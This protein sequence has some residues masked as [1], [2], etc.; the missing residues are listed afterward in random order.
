VGSA[1]EGTS[2]RNVYA[3]KDGGWV[4]IRP[5][6]QAMT[7]K[8]FSAFGRDDLNRDPAFKTNGE[9]GEAP[10]RRSTAIVGGFIKQRTLAD[11]ISFF[12]AAEVTAAPVYDIGQFLEDPHV[13]ERGIVVEAPD[14]DMGEVP[15][16]AWCRGSAA[17]PAACARRRRPSASTTA[18][19]SPA[20]ATPTSA[21]PRSLR[22]AS[23]DMAVHRARRSSLILPVNQ[24]RFVEKAYT[25]GADAIVLDLEDSVPPQEKATARKLVQGSL[26]VAGAAA[27]RCW[28]A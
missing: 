26:A 8:L 24:P 23:S 7:E 15:M 3:T 6:T 18:R 10:R 28:C 12:E 21:S 17:R 5:R 25:R 9:R 2:P 11:A 19:S 13:Q 22:K 4:A 20:S 1:S 16:H 14:D 27:P